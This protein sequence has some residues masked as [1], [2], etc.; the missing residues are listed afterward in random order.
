MA[1]EGIVTEM[2]DK[3]IRLDRDGAT[4]EADDDWTERLSAR[5]SRLAYKPDIRAA[6]KDHEF[7]KRLREARLDE[8]IT[9]AQANV[10][11]HSWRHVAIVRALARMPRRRARS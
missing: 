9:I 4:R 5:S 11:A 2:A 8:L 7:L 1:A 3:L 6:E 10:N